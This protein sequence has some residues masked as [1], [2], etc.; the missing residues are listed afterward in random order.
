MVGLNLNETT[1]FVAK[2]RFAPG[3]HLSD[4]GP[5]KAEEQDLLTW[6]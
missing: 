6:R 3:Q 4:C 2:N 5:R 1:L